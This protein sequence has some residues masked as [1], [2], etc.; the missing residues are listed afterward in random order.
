MIAVK[1]QEVSTISILKTLSRILDDPDYTKSLENMINNFTLRDFG[2]IG[3]KSSKWGLD[4][5]GDTMNKL[6]ED[7]FE[8]NTKPTVGDNFY[9]GDKIYKCCYGS[10]YVGLDDDEIPESGIR[11]SDMIVQLNTLPVR[12]TFGG[13]CLLKPSYVDV[14]KKEWV[15]L[16]FK[17]MYPRI[18]QKLIQNNKIT[19]N[20]PMFGVIYDKLVEARYKLENW[21][22]ICDAYDGIN[23]EHGGN[24]GNMGN[25]IRALLNYAYGALP[26]KKS[27][28][29]TSQIDLVGGYYKNIFNK[30]FDKFDT[31]AYIDTDE[32]WVDGMTELGRIGKELDKL[33]IPYGMEKKFEGKFVARKRFVMYDDNN[34]KSGRGAIAGCTLE[35]EDHIKSA[36]KEKESRTLTEKELL[37]LP[38]DL[39]NL[40]TEKVVRDKHPNHPELRLCEHCGR[41]IQVLSCIC[42]KG[43]EDFESMLKEVRTVADRG[44]ENIILPEKERVYNK[45]AYVTGAILQIRRDN[46]YMSEIQIFEEFKKLNE[47]W[48]E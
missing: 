38:I 15:K 47:D 33:D 44:E 24:T 43:K 45:A 18:L 40:A 31:I 11:D 48:E 10:S 27:M 20:N 7:H 4:E 30:I 32:I 41:K 22:L 16:E 28:F 13:I 9:R 19:F 1:K 14:W 39:Y 26:N 21:E 5:W 35:K 36:I 17:M 46:P 8:I 34:N 6:I 12:S 25:L 42:P 23:P 29:T 37:E 2:S 3:S